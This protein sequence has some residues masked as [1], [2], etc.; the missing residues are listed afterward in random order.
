NATRH[1]V[2]RQRGE[3]L[4]E[5]LGKGTEDVIVRDPAPLLGLDP[6]GP[7]AVLAAPFLEPR[8]EPDHVQ[9]RA[10][11]AHSSDGRAVVI[12]EVA[13]HG[14]AAGLG[15]GDRLPDLPPLEVALAWR[16]LGHRRSLQIGR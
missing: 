13:M 3:A 15:E 1:V 16:L 9:E 4:D 14:D 5:L 6:L 7:E 2:S 8:P 11:P 12:V 10:L